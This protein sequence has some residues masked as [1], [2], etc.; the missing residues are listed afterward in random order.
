MGSCSQCAKQILPGQ[1]DP[2]MQTPPRHAPISFYCWGD[3]LDLHSFPT[4]RSSDLA[5]G[6]WHHRRV[7]QRAAVATQPW[8]DRK[9]TRLNSSHTVKSYAVF[10][11]KKK[12]RLAPFLVELGKPP[13]SKLLLVHPTEY[14]CHLAQ[15]STPL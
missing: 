2:S 7:L 3:P 13:R 12:N 15:R 11:L 10:C 9:S 1:R 4:R 6:E 5:A 8:R 14:P